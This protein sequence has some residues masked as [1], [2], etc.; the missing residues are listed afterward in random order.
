MRIYPDGQAATAG[1]DTA[2]RGAEQRSRTLPIF[3]TVR[4]LR[5]NERRSA[6]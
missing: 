5:V 2:A 6:R 3:L 4:E 1:F